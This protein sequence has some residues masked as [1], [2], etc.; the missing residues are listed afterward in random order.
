ML[1]SF[2]VKSGD[3]SLIFITS[4]KVKIFTPEFW[5]LKALLKSSFIPVIISKLKVCLSKASLYNLLFSK[6]DLAS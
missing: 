3:I 6:I 1:L 5:P 4:F 2:K